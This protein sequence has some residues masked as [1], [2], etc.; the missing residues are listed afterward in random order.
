MGRH[1]SKH[2]SVSWENNLLEIDR[3]YTIHAQL[4]KKTS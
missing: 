2:R 3:I 4:T 1:Q